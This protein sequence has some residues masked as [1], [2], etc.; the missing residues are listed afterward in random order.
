MHLC[1]LPILG[2]LFTKGDIISVVKSS[3]KG[4][5]S[6]SVFMFVIRFILLAVGMKRQNVKSAT[7]I[8][9]IVGIIKL[10]T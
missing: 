5:S 7:Y 2:L 10:V 9:N 4:P 3:V 1:N 8:E 6:S